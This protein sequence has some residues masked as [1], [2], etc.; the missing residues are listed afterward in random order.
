MADI[1][2]W[3]TTADNNATADSDINW[4]EG[5]FPST[6]NNSAR[7]MMKRT[8]ELLTDLGGSITAGGTANALTVTASS[9]FSTV[10]NGRIVSFRAASDNT[11]AATLN[12]NSI[13]AKAIVKMTADGESA[14]A[15]GEIQA[16]GI[17]IVQYSAALASASGAWLLVN[18]SISAIPTGTIMDYAGSSAPTGW[19]FCY[20]QA[21]S[22]TTYA[23]L[24]AALS[25]TY[26]VG[27]GSSTFNLPDLRGRVVAGKDDMGGSSANRLTNQSGGLNGDTLGATGGSETHQLTS[28]QLAAHTH[29]VSGTTGAGGAHGHAFRLDVTDNSDSENGGGGFLVGNDNEQNFSA[30]TTTTPT[31][32]NGQQIGGAAD[33]THS[34]SAT[35]GSA[36]SDTAHNNVQPTFILNKIIKI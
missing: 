29:S 7:V 35:S 2:D 9:A 6:V 10:A 21:I 31:G 1:Y 18:P 23:A 24:F 34:F 11:G 26:G 27:D 14:L 20:G 33:H 13:G 36:G 28:G 8:K 17:Y 30:F 15:G 19:L 16:D 5:Q 22:R 12:V 4:Q 32:T 25:T 3:S